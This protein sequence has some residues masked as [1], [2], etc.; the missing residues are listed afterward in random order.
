[1]TELTEAYKEIA[2]SLEQLNSELGFK[3][4]GDRK[5]VV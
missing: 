2:K 5:S 4:S 1:M 3:K